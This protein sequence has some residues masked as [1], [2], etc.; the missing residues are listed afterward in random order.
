MVARRSR[1]NNRQGKRRGQAAERPDPL[2]W[3]CN[4]GITKSKRKRAKANRTAPTYV[5][6]TLSMATHN[7]V[8]VVAI[9]AVSGM[10]P[11]RSSGRRD[12]FKFATFAYKAA[13]EFSHNVPQP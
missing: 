9:T 4:A 11:A 5:S 13:V 12:G 1:N 3:E 6:S 8:N 2:S 10:V 7:L